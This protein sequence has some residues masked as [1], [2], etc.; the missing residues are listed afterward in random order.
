M[1]TTPEA[2]SVQL[3]PLPEFDITIHM[4]RQGQP[5]NFRF[6]NVPAMDERRAQDAGYQ[7]G[8]GINEGSGYEWKFMNMDA[9][10][11]VVAS[12]S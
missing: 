8:L 11:S 12:A 4:V 3:P 6:N 1:S 10:V 2:D 5:R 9:S 7:I